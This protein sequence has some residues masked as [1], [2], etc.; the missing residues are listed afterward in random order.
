[1]LKTSFMILYLCATGLKTIAKEASEERDQ[2]RGRHAGCMGRKRMRNDAVP[3][4]ST[5][6]TRNQMYIKTQWKK[7]HCN[8]EHITGQIYEDWEGNKEKSEKDMKKDKFMFMVL[9]NQHDAD[10]Y[11]PPFYSSQVTVISFHSICLFFGAAVIVTCA[12][13]LREG[14]KGD[15]SARLNAEKPRFLSWAHLVGLP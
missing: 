3:P 13:S 8:E 2:M 11:P 10:C 5:V 14:T 15:P 4:F 12:Y 6:V 1:M 9:Q 7:S